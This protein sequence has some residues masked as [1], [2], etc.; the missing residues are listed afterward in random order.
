[1]YIPPTPS[2]ML[3]I[4]SDTSTHRISTNARKRKH[5]RPQSQLNECDLHLNYRYQLW[6]EIT[7]TAHNTPTHMRAN[8]SHSGEE[9]MVGYFF[10]LKLHTLVVAQAAAANSYHSSSSS[11]STATEYLASPQPS[12][13]S[14]P[15]CVLWCRL[16]RMCAAKCCGDTIV[17]SYGTVVVVRDSPESSRALRVS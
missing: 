6:N 10:L 9:F 12:V 5:T 2:R 14:S 8:R 11:S 13:S 3:I 7:P 1:M 4:K 16:E 15:A 17:L